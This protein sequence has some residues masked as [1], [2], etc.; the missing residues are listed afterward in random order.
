VDKLLIKSN[1]LVGIL[2][3]DIGF[4]TKLRTL[5]LAEGYLAGPIPSSLVSLTV[6]HSLVRVFLHR[7]EFTGTIPDGLLQGGLDV[8]NKR[9][10]LETLSLYF[11]QLHEPA[12]LPESFLFV[13]LQPTELRN[14]FLA[15][16]AALSGTTP[17]SINEWTNLENRFT[18]LTSL[19]CTL[20][21][22]AG[23][24]PSHSNLD[25]GGN[26]HDG[27][28]P[29]ALFTYA[30]LSDVYLY[31]NALTGTLSP[32]IANWTDMSMLELNKNEL[33]GSLPFSELAVLKSLREFHVAGN[34]F[35]GSGFPHRSCGRYE[36]SWSKS[37][38]TR[39]V[40]QS[41]SGYA[42]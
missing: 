39:L 7:N 28:I 12:F 6:D 22:E 26:G 14:L 29:T 36:C 21:F 32:H 1:N 9:P 15:G 35:N 24:L 25:L 4:L 42:P 34:H 3:E 37:E 20:P 40:R 11:N 16:N 27:A 38:E 17:H 30:S 2:P 10:K 41:I 18:G 13:R 23:S 19:T 8:A 5:W 31:G 33:T